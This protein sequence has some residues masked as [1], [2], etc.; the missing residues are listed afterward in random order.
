MP[1][2]LFFLIFSVPL[3]PFPDWEGDVGYYSTGGAIADI[4]QDGLPDLVVS[5]GNDMRMEPNHVFFNEGYQ[6]GQNPGWISLDIA[7]SGHLSVTDIDGD[8]FMDLAV[9]SLIG[10]DWTRTRSVIYKNT[11]GSLDTLPYWVQGDSSMSFSCAFGDINHDGY[12]DLI[13]ASGNRY[14]GDKEPLRVYLN[15]GGVLDTLPSWQ[16]EYSYLGADVAIGDINND[17][18]IDVFLANDGEPNVLFLNLGDSLERVPSWHSYDSLG[19][20]QVVIGD[21]NLD[22]FQDVIVADNAQLQGISRVALYLNQSGVLDTVAS[23]YS[24]DNRDYYSTVT[25]GDVDRDGDLDIAAGGWW[26]PVVVFE[27]RDGEFSETPDWIWSPNNP[28]DLV[29]EKVTFGRALSAGVDTT[30]EFL[31]VDG[32]RTFYLSK[33]PFELVIEV[34]LNDSLLHPTEYSF[35]PEIGILELGVED[36]MLQGTLEV[37]Y[38]YALYPDL[39]VTNWEPSRGNFIFKNTAS[40]VAES[41]NRLRPSR[42]LM[43]PNPTRGRIFFRIGRLF[44]SNFVD[45]TLY[46][47]VGRVVGHL[48]SRVKG[49]MLILDMPSFLP[50]GLYYVKIGKL[51]TPKGFLYLP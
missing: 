11:G 12:P 25:L 48:R 15:Q 19:T 45:V 36:E 22:G 44:T 39:F 13:L 24:Q 5:N 32:K 40:L 20:L 41:G 4:N 21:V 42:F 47:D 6:F 37:K 50:G 2:I 27:N 26:E 14:V 17:G 29:C 9:A 28:Y 1:L 18:L 7:Y 3:N 38:T 33:I 31:N 35:Y 51:D 49:K 43:F 46:N 16:S 30:V 8:G 23:W 34:Y 10:Q